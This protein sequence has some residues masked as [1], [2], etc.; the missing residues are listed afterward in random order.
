MD[1]DL[2]P[3]FPQTPFPEVR[4]LT[5][6]TLSGNRKLLAASRHPPTSA[7]VERDRLLEPSYLLQDP[8]KL[9][10]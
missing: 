3:V 4:K 6:T 2:A 7:S 10:R 5:N 8:I 9:Q 1:L